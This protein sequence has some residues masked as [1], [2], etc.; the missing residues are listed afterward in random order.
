MPALWDQNQP[1]RI[2]KCFKLLH[3]MES[4]NHIL[5]AIHAEFAEIM[6]IAERNPGKF[7][8]KNLQPTTLA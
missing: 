5:L 7:R 4:I 3:K 1:D 6:A 8:S 2:T